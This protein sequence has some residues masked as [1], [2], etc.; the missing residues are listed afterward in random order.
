MKAKI[1]ATRKDPASILQ[2]IDQLKKIKASRGL[3]LQKSLELI[4]LQN[5]VGLWEEVKSQMV[6]IIRQYGDDPVVW[7]TYVS[8]LIEHDEFG[9]AEQRQ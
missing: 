7:N 4:Q 9:L 5:R 1:L 3:D 8:L 6:D 2:A